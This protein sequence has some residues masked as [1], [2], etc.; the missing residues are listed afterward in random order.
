[1]SNNVGPWQCHIILLEDIRIKCPKYFFLFNFFLIK[2][3][4]MEEIVEARKG[5]RKRKRMLWSDE[6]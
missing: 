5:K 2:G 4:K 6:G 3:N 1:M